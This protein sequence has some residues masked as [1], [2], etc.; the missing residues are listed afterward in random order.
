MTHSEVKDGA[1]EALLLN[2]SWTFVPILPDDG[3]ELFPQWPPHSSSVKAKNCT[4]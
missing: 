2:R 3:A 4:P 1:K